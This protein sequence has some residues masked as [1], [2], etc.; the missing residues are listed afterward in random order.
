MPEIVD[1]LILDPPEFA[2]GRTP[3]DLTGAGLSVVEAEFGEATIE[4][5]LIRQQLGEAVTHRHEPNKEIGFKLQ[6]RAEGEVSLPEVATTLQ[7]K[8]GVLA[9]EGG[10]LQRDFK[11]GGEFGSLACEVK[12][13]TLA[14]FAGW[15]RGESPDVTLALLCGPLWYATEEIESPVFKLENGRAL[16]FTLPEVEGTG[17]GLIRCRVKNTGATD[18]RGMVLAL[19]SQDHPQDATAST[20]AKLVYQA[21][22]LTPAG[23][24]TVATRVDESVSHSVVRANLTAGWT[25]ILHSTIGG[26]GHMT[27]VGPRRLRV[28]VYD[29]SSSAGGV[30]LNAQFRPLGA[31]AWSDTFVI[32]PTQV[33]GK[34]SLLDLGECRPERAVLGTQRWEWRILAR[35]LSGSGSID[36]DT[37][38]I[39]PVEQHAVV[40]APDMSSANESDE[41]K[42]PGKGETVAT[43]AGAAVWSNP[44][45]IKASDESKA[46]AEL[47]SG[48]GSSNYLRAS[49][50]AFAIPEDASVIA[51]E[52]KIKRSASEAGKIEDIAVR[53]TKGTPPGFGGGGW[54]WEDHID[55]NRFWTT[56]E[57][58]R[59]YP[60]SKAFKWWGLPTPVEVNSSDFSVWLWVINDP[61]TGSPIARVDHISL[62]VYYALSEEASICY[63]SRSVEFRSD[64]ILRQH[65]IDNVWGE[66]INEGFSLYS[67]PSYMEG[68][69]A[70]GL[71]VPSAGDLDGLADSGA[72]SLEAQVFYRPGFP[73]AREAA[74]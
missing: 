54:A 66:L 13:A 11:V 3:L 63:Q 15:Q 22:S 51:L 68:R 72:H 61:L 8:V 47:K 74:E 39:E 9:R 65:P 14:N 20:T 45:N 48:Q 34:F 56:S 23:G 73:F 41:L 29:P 50:F 44:E 31:L 55:P 70:R 1:R 67:P 35:A 59:V 42:S 10:W 46:T 52:P 32:R 25:T 26:V 64:G 4:T 60:P 43:G 37:V 12:R 57:Q 17:P 38:Y 27:H 21:E 24:A 30:E 62:T 5:E 6:V 33:V 28:R 58:V 2:L 69:A 19:E 16:E 71:I 53:V 40:R 36:V 7:Q 49:N 18:L